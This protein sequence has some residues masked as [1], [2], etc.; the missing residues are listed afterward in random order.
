MDFT[1]LVL[2]SGTGEDLG[3]RFWKS[4]GETTPEVLPYNEHELTFMLLDHRLLVAG[5][6][7]WGAGTL[8]LRLL[9]Q[10]LFVPQAGPRLIVV[11]LAGFLACGWIVRTLCRRFRL[12]VEQWPAAASAVVLPTLLLDPVSTLWFGSVFP[13]I[14][15]G[16]APVFAAWIL[17]CCAGGVIGASVRPRHHA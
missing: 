1:A 13:N 11:F 15:P 12:S 9:G 7:F 17:A 4:K 3:C 6:V 16:M 10:Y 8:A 2:V 5:L 14:E